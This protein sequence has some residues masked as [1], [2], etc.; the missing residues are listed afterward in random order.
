MLGFAP[1]SVARENLGEVSLFFTFC[2]LSM[3]LIGG[4]PAYGH[5]GT[6][7][8]AGCQES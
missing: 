4:L 1:H 8:R 7:S 5:G 2:A 6:A 3:T